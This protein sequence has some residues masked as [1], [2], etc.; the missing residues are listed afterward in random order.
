MPLSEYELSVMQ[1][2]GMQIQAAGPLSLLRTGGM[3]F[4]EVVDDMSKMVM[5]LVQRDSEKITYD[6]DGY[7]NV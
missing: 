2:A 1:R 4:I 7:S 6:Q 5:T 3:N